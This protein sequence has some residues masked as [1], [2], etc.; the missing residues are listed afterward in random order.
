MVLFAISSKLI[1]T[2][3]IH[4]TLLFIIPYSFPSYFTS[5]TLI[6]T[7]SWFSLSFASMF[8]MHPFPSHSSSQPLPSHSLLSISIPILS[9]HSISSFPVI[10]YFSFDSSFSHVQWYHP[11]SLSSL[12]SVF[13]HSY[14]FH[15]FLSLI[16]FLFYGADLIHL[17]SS[18]L[19]L[20]TSLYLLSFSINLDS[21]LCSMYYDLSI[22]FPYLSLITPLSFYSI[23]FSAYS[24]PVSPMPLISSVFIPLFVIALNFSFPF[25]LISTHPIL[26]FLAFYSISILQSIFFSVTLSSLI[27]LL[28]SHSSSHS[29]SLSLF[30]IFLSF[31]PFIPFHIILSLSFY[32]HS[33]LHLFPFQHHSP[34]LFFLSLLQTTI[35]FDSLLLFSSL[36]PYS[37]LLSFSSYISIPFF[38]IYSRN[39][40]SIHSL[41]SYPFTHILLSSRLLYS[42]EEL[43]SNKSKGQLLVQRELGLYL[44]NC[45]LCITPA[46]S[47]WILFLFRLYSV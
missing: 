46:P 12:H 1:F 34:F 2:H 39:I 9:F 25:I 47:D 44:P 4:H 31:F 43:H 23:S 16:P 36:F 3:F 20:I 45:E 28:P 11:P 40:Y 30:I 26:S 22:S 33:V 29:H 27:I 18:L 13:T 6:T 38:L 21:I 35:G 5:I 19:T 17:I 37:F 8:F 41:L 14:A 32:S 10:C 7:L 24:Y 42:A 15:R